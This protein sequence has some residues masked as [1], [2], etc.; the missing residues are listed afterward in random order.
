MTMSCRRNNW[1][2]NGTMASMMTLTMSSGMSLSYYGQPTKEIVDARLDLE[3]VY[4]ATDERRLVQS[5]RVGES[6]LALGPG[7]ICKGCGD[8]NPAGG[9]LCIKCGAPAR[10]VPFIAPQD[11]PFIAESTS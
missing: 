10:Q 5:V 9:V 1:V 7:W 2:I 6:L 11:F 4:R 3:L 8:Y